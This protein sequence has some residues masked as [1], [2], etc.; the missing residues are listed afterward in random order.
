M[1]TELKKRIIAA[2]K[3]VTSGSAPMRIPVD[4]TD[5]DIVLADCYDFLEA[6]EARLREWEVKEKCNNPH[7]P[8]PSLKCLRCGD[9]GFITSPATFND[10]MD[11]F[12]TYPNTIGIIPLADGRE[13]R[14]KK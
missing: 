14:R 13:L 3:R 9:T 4:N 10:V 11:F 7:I 12:D 1:I 5:P 2:I 8:I 6:Q